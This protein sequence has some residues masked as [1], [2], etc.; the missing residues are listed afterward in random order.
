MSDN[1]PTTTAEFLRKF[2]EE[3]SK[4]HSEQ[5]VDAL[6]LHAGKSLVDND[7]LAVSR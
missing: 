1:K 6:V 4:D 7:G 5:I 2:R 3:L